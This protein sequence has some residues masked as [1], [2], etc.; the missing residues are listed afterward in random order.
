VFSERVM[1][2]PRSCAMERNSSPNQC[3]SSLRPCPLAAGKQLVTK[4][5]IEPAF[6]AMVLGAERFETGPVGNVWMD[7]VAVNGTQ[8]GCN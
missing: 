1:L 5:W 8:V 4:M 7:H 3:S 2:T 6:V